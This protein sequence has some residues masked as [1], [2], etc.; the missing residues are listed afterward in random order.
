MKL[1]QALKAFAPQA[2]AEAQAEKARKTHRTWQTSLA[3]RSPEAAAAAC[4]PCLEV[5]FTGTSANG[6]KACLWYACTRCGEQRALWAFR[7]LPCKARVRVDEG[8]LSRQAWTAAVWGRAAAARKKKDDKERLKA[9]CRTDRGRERLSEI[10]KKRRQKR[11]QIAAAEGVPQRVRKR[12][13][14]APRS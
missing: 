2:A 9:W 6:T 11:K 8:G 5:P 3:R 7:R 10:D 12:P 14:A 4:S 1:R 13:A